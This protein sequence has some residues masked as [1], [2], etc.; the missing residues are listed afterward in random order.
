[1]STQEVVSLS[2]HEDSKEDSEVMED[3]FQNHHRTV[4]DE[5]RKDEHKQNHKPVTIS[6][7]RNSFDQIFAKYAKFSSNS[8]YMERG[9]KLVQWVMWLCSQVTKNNQRFHR[10]LSP[11]LRKIYSDLSMMRYVLRFYGFVPALDA[12]TQSPSGCW[13]GSPPYSPCWKDGRIVKLANVMAWSMVFYHPLEHIAYANWK[14]PKVLHRVNGNKMSAWSCR[15]WLVYILADWLSSFL[16][17]VELLEYRKKLMLLQDRQDL[18]GVGCN[19]GNNDDDSTQLKL[20]LVDKTIFFNK[21]QMVRNFFFAPPCLS[22]SLN[23]WD[24]DPLLSENIINGMSLAEA[25]VCLYQ[26]I[27][28]L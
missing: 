15:F 7:T 27:L 19:K 14:M 24:T 23:K 5:K 20:R 22:W 13:A 10:E 4:G 25:V 12:A 2:S 18:D 8:L 9:L 21:L 1:M 26:T 3:E 17:N 16:K 6:T 28:S 11:S